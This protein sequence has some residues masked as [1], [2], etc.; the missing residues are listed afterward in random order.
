MQTAGRGGQREK[1]RVGGENICVG[2]SED[3]EPNRYER[4]RERERGVG[5]V[6]LSYLALMSMMKG[7]APC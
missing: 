6:P 3:G 4:E 1:E 2:L 5:I 7:I